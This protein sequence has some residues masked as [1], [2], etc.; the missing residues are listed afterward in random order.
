MVCGDPKHKKKLYFCNKF[1]NLSPFQKIDAT[2][3]LGACKECLEVHERDQYCKPFYICKNQ[4]CVDEDVQDHHFLLCQNKSPS[5][6]TGSTLVGGR[7]RF[8]VE[9]ETF[10][11]QLSPQLALQCKNAFSNATH[12]LVSRA[13]N[14]AGEEGS[15]LTRSELSEQPVIMMLQYVT[16][17]AGQ[18]IGTLIDLASDTNYIT[19]KT[20]KDL[21]LQSEPVTLVVHGVGGMTTSVKTKRYL[22]K[23]R[24]KTPEGMLKSHQLICYGLD[25]IAKV[26]NHVSAQALQKL[27]PEVPIHELQRPKKIQL[28][29]SH[30]EGQLAPNKLCAVGNLVLWDG[31]LG[32]AIGGTHPALF[33]KMSISEHCSKTHFARSMWVTATKDKI[34]TCSFPRQM[35][36]A[37]ATCNT[38]HGH[39][40]REVQLGAKEKAKP[41]MKHKVHNDHSG[42]SNPS[43]SKSKPL[44]SRWQ[45]RPSQALSGRTSNQSFI[46]KS[47][48]FRRQEESCFSISKVTNCKNT[49]FRSTYRK[50]SHV[51]VKTPAKYSHA[52]DPGVGPSNSRPVWRSSLSRL[53]CCATSMRKPHELEWEVLRRTGRHPALPPR[54]QPEPIT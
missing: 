51:P 3:K 1:K 27:F 33:K 41:G 42:R 29:I 32:K 15:L 53:E 26:H 9:Q 11:A 49:G 38:R 52:T 18:Q 28:L 7:S 44:G 40:N 17:N 13:F 30:K 6:R 39:C 24:V 34:L 36:D 2:E 35:L 4:E 50:E 14:T 12:R 48:S 8:T 43:L 45:M 31:P 16:A 23:L 37:P 54:H 19:H 22:L 46:T 47:G 20:A 10:M 5:Q 25:H 21:H